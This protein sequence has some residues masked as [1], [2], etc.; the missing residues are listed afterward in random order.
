[1][2]GVLVVSAVAFIAVRAGMPSDLT[3]TVP[4]KGWR[5]DGA[6]VAAIRGGDTGLRSGD[7]VMAIDGRKLTNRAVPRASVGQ[8]LRYTVRREGRLVDV[9]VTLRPYPLRQALAAGW[10]T[11]VFAALLL[12]LGGY[13]FARRPALPAARGLFMI[14]C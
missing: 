1:M 12:V 5:D 10:S 4:H 11:I 2:A 6:V 13:V 8:R 9:P 7:L 3:S 14:A